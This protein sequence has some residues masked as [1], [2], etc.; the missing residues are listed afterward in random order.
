MSSEFFE[1][2]I[3]NSPYE[4]P[5][6]HWVLDESG[7]PTGAKANTR[8][9]A[10]FI[11]PIPKPKKRKGGK[12]AELDLD[13]SGVGTAAQK[14][15][16][17]SIIN[18]VRQNVDAWRALP[19]S[20]WQVT[21]VTAALLQHWRHH[22]FGIIRPFFCQVEAVETVIW[23]TEVASHLIAGK[24]LL[25][26]LAAANQDA[27]PLLD[28]LALK[29]AT[30][31]G[32]TTVMAMLIAWQTL[33]AVR[34]EGSKRFTKGFLIVTPGLTI[35]RIDSYCYTVSFSRVAGT[36]LPDKNQSSV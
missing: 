17:T 27:N 33:N 21:P 8:R 25:E 28:R 16:L 32:K 7:Q 24:R 14:Y 10:D 9:R 11:T 20:Q 36:K 18:E 29:L 26:H 23:L 5:H 1:H 19:A 2:P 4:Y 30:G 6:T 3:I 22:Q 34:H 31:A 15:D 13:A 35:N 12:Q